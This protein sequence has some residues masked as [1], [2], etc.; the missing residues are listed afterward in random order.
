MVRVGVLG[1]AGSVSLFGVSDLATLVSLFGVNTVPDTRK[2]FPVIS[3]RKLGYK[4]LN[5]R[6]NDVLTCLE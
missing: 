5:L 6:R 2:N 3:R 4:S 1:F